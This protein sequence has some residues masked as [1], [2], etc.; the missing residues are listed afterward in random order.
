MY[1]PL[2]LSRPARAVELDTCGLW[3]SVHWCVADFAVD[4]R[5]EGNR[6]L[7]FLYVS[8]RAAI[9]VCRH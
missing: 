1:P 5:L 4:V 6:V 3:L 8:I 9:D 2:F 7:D